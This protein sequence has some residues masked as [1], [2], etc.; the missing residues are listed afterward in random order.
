MLASRQPW[1]ELDVSNKLFMVGLMGRS[2]F[3]VVKGLAF[4][5]KSLQVSLLY[6]KTYKKCFSFETVFLVVCAVKI[7]ILMPDVFIYELNWLFYAL[8]LNSSL[9][10]TLSFELRRRTNRMTDAPEATHRGSVAWFGLRMAFLAFIMITP[11]IDFFDKEAPHYLV[12]D[13]ILYRKCL[14]G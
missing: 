8:A 10:Y 6:K 4:V 2:A 9:A 12:C 14:P 11:A 1:G 5:G 13:P 7:L 3:M